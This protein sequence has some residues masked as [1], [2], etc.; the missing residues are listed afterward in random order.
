MNS[1]S[2]YLK[3]LEAQ[4]I[5][6]GGNKV[7][8]EEYSSHLEAEFNDFIASQMIAED[9]H[10]NEEVFVHQLESPEVIAQSLLGVEE[11]R[12]KLAENISQFIIISSQKMNR[13]YGYCRNKYDLL[14]RL[15]SKYRTP[16]LTALLYFFV[17][18]IPLY[19]YTLIR[20]L[21]FDTPPVGFREGIIV[22]LF[23]FAII[24]AL[25]WKY[26]FRDAV[27]SAFFF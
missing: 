24:A 7:L 27:Q 5:A 10:L 15:Y 19:L 23:I 6:L 22:I 25:G 20:N 1:I 13:I 8:A 9:I 11:E 18:M 17:A 4:I 3:E 21:L 16:P 14:S 12:E 2:Q 26:P